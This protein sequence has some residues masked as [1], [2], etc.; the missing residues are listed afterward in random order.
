MPRPAPVNEAAL[1]R[2]AKQCFAGGVLAGAVGVWVVDWPSAALAGFGLGVAVLLASEI[3]I[4][5]VRWVQGPV[6][7]LA[8][9]LRAVLF[10]SV[11]AV[12][13]YGVLTPLAA[14]ARRLRRLPAA[15]GPGPMGNSFWRPRKSRVRISSH[16]PL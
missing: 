12:A 10:N 8:R 15:S 5:A 7:A 4:S 6:S 14:A 3:R 13:H 9:P 2:F 11:L 16:T 1:R